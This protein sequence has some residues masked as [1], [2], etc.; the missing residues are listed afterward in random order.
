MRRLI[1]AGL[2]PLLAVLLVAT[3]VGA[4]PDTGSPHVVATIA[5]GRGPIGVAVDS[6]TDLIYVANSGS[7]TVSVING[8]TNRVVA[9]VSVGGLPEGVAVDSTTDLI[10]VTN[11][12]SGTVSVIRG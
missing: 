2:G 8:A 6:T 10:Y 4:A 1:V 12:R 11:N 7:S 3:S 9:T 5:V